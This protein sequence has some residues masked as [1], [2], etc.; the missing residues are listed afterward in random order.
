MVIREG[1]S[2]SIRAMQKESMLRKLSIVPGII[3][4]YTEAYIYDILYNEV[5]EQSPDIL[6]SRASIHITVTS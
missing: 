3:H 2:V 4:H 6:S 1:Q 5:V